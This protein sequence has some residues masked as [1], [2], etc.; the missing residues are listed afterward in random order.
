MF[1]SEKEESGTVQDHDFSHLI[2]IFCG[3]CQTTSKG[4]TDQTDQIRCCGIR[5]LQ[6]VLRKS[7]EQKQRDELIKQYADIIIP[8]LLFNLH[9]ENIESDNTSNDSIDD[10]SP[11]GLSDQVLRDLLSRITM[12]QIKLVIHPLLKHLDSN[13]LWPSDNAVSWAQLFMKSVRESYSHL[14]IKLILGEFY[15]LVFKFNHF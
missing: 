11:R 14:I 2:K 5:G 1:K 3:L 12:D 7:M 10:E 4:D 15:Q 13:N 6:G 8:S 9:I